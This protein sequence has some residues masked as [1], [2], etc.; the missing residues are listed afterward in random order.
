MA[1]KLVC[2]QCGGKMRITT[3]GVHVY[4]GGPSPI[5]KLRCD[6]CDI[7]RFENREDIERE[8]AEES[9][10]S[11]NQSTKVPQTGTAPESKKWW[12]FWK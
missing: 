11:A 4:G 2:N 7:T 8:L 6:K 3:E 1:K 12:Q 9:G 10:P 5:V